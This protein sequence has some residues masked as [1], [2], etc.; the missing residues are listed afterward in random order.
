MSIWCDN[1]ARAAAA[2]GL[3]SAGRAFALQRVVTSLA[4]YLLI[5]RGDMFNVGDRIKMGGVRGDVIRIGFIQ[6]TI[7]E[8]GQPPAA[9][10]EQPG[11]WVEARQ[12]SGRIVSVSNAMIFDEP[13]YNYSRDFP[14]IWEEMHIP[15]S[16]K[17]DRSAAEQI[18]LRAAADCALRD[19]DV[20][21]EAMR[22]L[23]RRYFMKAASV[24][25]RVYWRITDNWVELSVRL[26]TS[27]EGAAA[28]GR[29]GPA[30]LVS[31]RLSPFF[32]KN[33][34]CHHFSQKMGTVPFIALERW[35]CT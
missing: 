4:G 29:P 6:M 7:M 3:A 9:Q 16:F 13:V 17:D 20:P 34:D 26:V 31:L 15:I 28:E 10:S 14:F 18:L 11:M 27:V 33:G 30:P 35:R 2:L 8:M 5:L 23:A 24:E 19:R 12:Y 21:E 25:P 32:A 1:P 22:E